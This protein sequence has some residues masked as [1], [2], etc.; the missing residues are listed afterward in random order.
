MWGMN[1]DV[2]EHLKF[3]V[4]VSSWQEME[5]LIP[6]LQLY[7]NKDLKNFVLLNCW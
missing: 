6:V 3:I 7:K 5:M 4:V 2:R 1:Q